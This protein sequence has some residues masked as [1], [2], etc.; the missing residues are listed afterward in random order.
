MKKLL[1]I[2]AVMVMLF[3]GCQLTDNNPYVDTEISFVNTS[4]DTIAIQF[5]RNPIKFETVPNLFGE[6][7][8][9]FPNGTKKMKTQNSS[10]L[11]GVNILSILDSVQIFVNNEYKRTDS[12]RTSVFNPENK[13]SFFD[14]ALYKAYECGENCEGAELEVDLLFVENV[15]S[16]AKS[17]PT[18]MRNSHKSTATHIRGLSRS[19]QLY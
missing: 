10:R 7:I 12:I 11:G 13:N 4:Q 2:N 3:F 16:N 15:D 9:C 6:H 14:I 8:V 1:K 5:F 18:S 17:I 19:H